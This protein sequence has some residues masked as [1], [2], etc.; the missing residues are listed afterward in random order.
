MVPAN[1]GLIGSRGDYT[2][3]VSSNLGFAGFGTRERF[4][5]P[6]AVELIRII[7]H[8]G[9]YGGGIER[10]EYGRVEL[11][12]VMIDG[13]CKGRRL[14]GGAQEWVPLARIDDPQGATAVMRGMWACTS[15]L[16]GRRQPPSIKGYRIAGPVIQRRHDVRSDEYVRIACLDQE[17]VDRAEWDFASCGAGTLPTTLHLH[18][19]GDR[20]SSRADR[21]V[22]IELGCAPARIA[23]VYNVGH[24]WDELNG[25]VFTY[26][27]RHIVGLENPV[28]AG[29]DRN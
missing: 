6:C 5:K 10:G 15:R 23:Y 17:G 29:S 22:G 8:N 25:R 19:A 14:T 4:D 13:P 18:F 27:I 21:L 9:G 11:E 7:G 3:I 12:R 16:S 2:M 1:G 20:A 26:D 24:G 28:G